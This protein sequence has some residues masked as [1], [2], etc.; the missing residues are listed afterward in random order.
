MSFEAILAALFKLLGPIVYQYS[1]E[2]VMWL[3]R[4]LGII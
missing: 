2:F 3:A 1:S 4:L